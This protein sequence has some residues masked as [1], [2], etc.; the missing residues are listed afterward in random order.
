MSLEGRQSRPGQERDKAPPLRLESS[1][2]AAPRCCL[3]ARCFSALGGRAGGGYACHSRSAL[4]RRAGLCPGLHISAGWLDTHQEPL[5]VAPLVAL[6]SR[7]VTGWAGRG[8][9]AVRVWPADGGAM[10]EVGEEFGCEGRASRRGCRVVLPRR[11]NNDQGPR[12]RMKKNRR[13]EG[14]RGYEGVLG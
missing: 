2:S 8:S 11:G 1:P 4:G 12:R 9:G 10:K 3:N 5:E 13:L 14:A 7:G 6:G